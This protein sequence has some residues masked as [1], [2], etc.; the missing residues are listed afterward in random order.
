MCLLIYID[1]SVNERN[2]I[3]YDVQI[4]LLP[5]FLVHIIFT[6]YKKHSLENHWYITHLT[7]TLRSGHWAHNCKMAY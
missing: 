3:S 4:I 7:F 2:L 1:L 6:K 5:H